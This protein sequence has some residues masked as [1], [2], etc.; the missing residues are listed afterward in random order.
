MSP[1]REGAWETLPRGPGSDARHRQL[2]GQLLSAHVT[3]RSQPRRGDSRGTRGDLGCS[4]V[5]RPPRPT[6]AVCLATRPQKVRAGNL[7]SA[8][9]PPPEP[10]RAGVPGGRT[11]QGEQ[12]H[13]PV[14]V[15][16]PHCRRSRP[17]RSGLPEVAV[18]LCPWPGH[19]TLTP[20]RRAEKQGGGRRNLITF[21]REGPLLWARTP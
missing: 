21:T 9:P 20:E 15:T 4:G 1:G 12:R 6:P 3:A 13:L 16:V 10:R 11:A 14:S 5:A 8:W 2:R 17:V 7:S 19:G 18:H